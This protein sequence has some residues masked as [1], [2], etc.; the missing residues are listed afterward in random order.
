MELDNGSIKMPQV[1]LNSSTVNQEKSSTISRLLTCNIN[2]NNK[3]AILTLKKEHIITM[4]KLPLKPNFLPKKKGIK[5]EL[6]E[7]IIKKNIYC[8][9]K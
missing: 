8:F 1:T 5:K 9:I 3:T 4:Q 6:N 7:D 2:K